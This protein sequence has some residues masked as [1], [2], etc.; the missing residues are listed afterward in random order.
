MAK[1]LVTLGLILL[2]LGALWPWAAKLGLGRLPGDIVIERG[3]SRFCFPI[4]S[5]LILSLALSL[6][7]FLFRR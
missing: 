1:S 3:N 5:S 7:L 4:T 6:I 2:A